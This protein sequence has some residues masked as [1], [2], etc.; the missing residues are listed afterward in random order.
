MVP[1]ADILLSSA[2]ACVCNAVS[3][4]FS[5]AINLVTMLSTSKPLPR[6]ADETVAISFAPAAEWP[7]SGEREIR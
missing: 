7:K 5:I 2:V 4:F 3:G 1:K 6:P